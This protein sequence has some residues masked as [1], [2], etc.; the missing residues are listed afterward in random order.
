MLIDEGIYACTLTLTQTRML[1]QCES[2]VAVARPCS[3]PAA[4]AGVA[5]VGTNAA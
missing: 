2:G 1:T 5:G 4:D 3:D